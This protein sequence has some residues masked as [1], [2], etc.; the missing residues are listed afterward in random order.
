[1][2]NI[3]DIA[4]ASGVSVATVSRALAKPELVRH[5]TLQKVNAAIAA[6]GYMPNAMAS[7]LRRKRS[8][9]LL[10]VIPNLH[11][12]FYSG[13]VEGVERIADREGLRILLGETRGE[14]H[15][16]DI[17]ADML[18]K[19]QA[20]GMILLGEMVP[21]GMDAA[22]HLKNRIVM[23]CEYPADVRV[24]RVR[25]DNERAAHEAVGYLATLGHRRIASITGP[26]DG[27][28]GRKR[29]QGYVSALKEQGLEFDERLV[30][31]GTF[32][33]ESGVIA[34]QRLLCLRDS[35]TAVFCA[36]D[37]MAIGAMQALW[38]A[39]LQ[40]PADCSVIGFDDIRFA[41]YSSPPLTTVA[42]PTVEIGMAAMELMLRCLND[43]QGMD[44]EE[45]LPHRLIVRSSTAVLR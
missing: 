42:Q 2:A 35:P 45:T 22:A 37:E 24:P 21:T 40:V 44:R 6:L 26:A 43:E 3:K 10:V 14:Q 32:E 16:L 5:E 8:D 38:Q 33:F 4:R 36:N 27:T 17:Y 19:K 9:T 25:I 34:M 29:Q 28:L 20:D 39:G 30:G 18:A 13:V 23:A 7:S 11:N 31:E 15:R 1:M 12:P 41:A